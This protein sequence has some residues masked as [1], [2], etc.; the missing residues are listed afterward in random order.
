MALT[1]AQRRMLAIGLVPLLVLVVTGA[2]VTVSTIRGKVPYEYSASF[3]PGAQGVQIVSDSHTQVLASADGHV[4]VAVDGSYAAEQPAI[5][6]NTTDGRLHIQAKCP[7][8]HCELDLTVEV[9]SQSAVQ[10]ELEGDSVDV[11]GVSSPLAI[12]VSGGS[13]TTNRLRSRQ[14][15]VDGRRGS[16]DLN[17]ESPP[18][19]V[20]AKASDGSLTVQLPRNVTY[21]FDAVA[22]Q[23]SSDLELP[24]DPASPRHVI[25]RTN[26]GSITVN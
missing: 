14:V 25:L 11:V 26:S 21:A 16:I 6:I 10:V 13:V 9:P 4:H 22:S 12:E 23:G 8:T 2:A 24:S 15:S 17:F 20:T 3:V 19:Q 18:D 1:V 7:D 5:D